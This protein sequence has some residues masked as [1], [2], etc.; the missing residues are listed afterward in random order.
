MYFTPRRYPYRVLDSAERAVIVAGA[1]PVGLAVALGLARRG[2]KVTLLE[3]G[4]SV[5]FGSRAICLSRHSL[6]VL[7]R[8]G[9][10]PAITRQALPWMT[11]RSYFRDVEVLTFEMP[12]SDGD[13]HPPMVNISQSAVEQALVDAAGH[14]PNLTI[15]WR[16]KLLFVTPGEDS[17]RVTASTPRG[18]HDLTTRWLVAA[19]GARSTVRDDLGL[20]LKGTSYN[21]QSLIADI[22]WKAGLPAERRVWFDPPASPGQTVILHR[23]P[24]DIWRFDCQLPPDADLVAELEPQRVHQL[25]K[26]HL[27]WLGNT[28]PWTVQWSSCY[29]AR[30]MSLDSY[31]H[32]RVVFTGD[33]AHL[34]PIFGVRGLNSGLADADT[35]AW[36]L[37]AVAAGTADRKLLTAYAY[38][39]RE[40]WRQ[41]IAQAD[42]STR[43]MMPGTAG[44][45][46]TRDAV[47]ALALLHPELADLIN[48]RQTAATHART[49]PL[50]LPCAS[51]PTPA[52]CL[53]P[54]D[55]VPDL[56]IRVGGQSAS[57]HGER[58]PDLTLLAFGVADACTLTGI[59]STLR[60]RLRPALGVR[61]LIPD[62][63]DSVAAS[64]DAGR[65][66]VLVIRPDGLLLARYACAAAIDPEALA[67]HVC[68]GGPA[69]TPAEREVLIP[70][71][72]LSPAEKV[73]RSVSD[74]LDNV[75]PDDR[76]AFLTRL[77]LMLALDR[78]DPSTATPLIAQALGN[79]LL[80]GL[81]T[82]RQDPPGD[83][84]EGDA[85][86]AGTRR[87][88]GDDHIVAVGQ[89]RPLLAVDR[90]RFGTAPGQLQ[91]RAPLEALRT[92]D[93]ARP[94]QVS[95]AR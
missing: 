59:V 17:V 51:P 35:L 42:L 85:P 76:V 90:D 27:D 31:V 16:Y 78:P 25:I 63:G 45:R 86:A 48:P 22:H 40:A 14:E 81:V 75:P 83:C 19:D 26:T 21:G 58:G 18:L 87:G 29:S 10:G 69:V 56:A 60:S 55:P 13:P 5:C 24:G 61:L 32:G 33:A 92:G 68:G 64:L 72:E 53:R 43:F 66:E 34:L 8:L 84:A 41:N 44:Y 82:G 93:R 91:E 95:G 50:T 6:E 79:T 47:L 62:D 36:T 1:G 28:E 37:A 49:S 70:R 20:H 11:G 3:A 12:H 77:V 65:T 23:Q 94:E 38:E 30:A 54:G 9:A 67:A 52:P 2:I 46:A 88:R 39:R 74:A 89:E 80:A 4:D 71:H 73:W 15:A 57:L 7:D